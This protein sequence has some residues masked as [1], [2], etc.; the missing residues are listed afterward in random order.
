ML[1]HIRAVMREFVDKEL[2]PYA[3][4]WNESRAIPIQLFKKAYAAGNALLRI[5]YESNAQ[6]NRLATGYYW[7]TVACEVWWG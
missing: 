6:L 4:E 2:T 5:F 7:E 1:T 3:H